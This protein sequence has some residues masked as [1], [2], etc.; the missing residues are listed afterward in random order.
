MFHYNYRSLFRQFRVVT[1]IPFRTSRAP[2]EWAT[3]PD[4]H[5]YLSCT[6]E[7][8][9]A[10]DTFLLETQFRTIRHH[11][12]L[13]HLDYYILQQNSTTMLNY[14][15][16]QRSFWASLDN[17]LDVLRW[18]LMMYTQHLP[19]NNPLGIP[20]SDMMTHVDQILDRITR[21]I[22]ARPQQN[23]LQRMRPPDYIPNR[24]CEEVKGPPLT[25]RH[26][27]L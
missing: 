1:M 7:E 26:S 20:T 22:H 8:L 4:Y 12:L 24:L 15:Q 18:K 23:L 5:L 21:E 9:R 6:L 17:N 3:P 2:T 16:S 19:E 11:Y 13:H 10:K 14:I 27:G 25:R